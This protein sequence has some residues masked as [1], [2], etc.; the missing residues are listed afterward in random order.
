MEKIDDFINGFLEHEKLKESSSKQEQIDSQKA[1]MEIE[2]F[3]LDF[4]NY[5]D[6]I[7]KPKLEKLKTKL[8]KHA[9]IVIS[10]EKIKQI[11][12]DE[13]VFK[14]LIKKTSH[15]D[16]SISIRGNTRKKNIRISR[17]SKNEQD[18]LSHK[19]YE[20][21]FDELDSDKLEKI[22]IENLESHYEI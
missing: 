14:I 22:L 11:Q 21:T 17:K 4:Q 6:N 3:I 15:K 16:L 7:V 9:F 1:K 20:F 10:D 2:K 8:S 5:V 13:F 19:R 18:S 12:S